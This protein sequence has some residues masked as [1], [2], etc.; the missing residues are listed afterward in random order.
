M[1]AQVKADG[2]T[3]ILIFTEDDPKLKENV[4]EIVD[5]DVDI[6]FKGLGISFVDYRPKEVAYISVQGVKLQYSQSNL[7][8]KIL[9][10]INNFQVFFNM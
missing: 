2:P 4:E 1:Y 3:K 6:Y 8:Q 10:V 9:F 5:M 7:D